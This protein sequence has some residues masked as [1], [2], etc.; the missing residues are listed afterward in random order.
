MASIYL[1]AIIDRNDITQQS[2]ANDKAQPLLSPG[3]M[4]AV[5]QTVVIHVNTSWC[6]AK[7]GK[8]NQLFGRSFL[9]S[10]AC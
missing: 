4:G 6:L 8:F 10:K 1:Y 9:V 7:A 2:D 3:G 5:Y